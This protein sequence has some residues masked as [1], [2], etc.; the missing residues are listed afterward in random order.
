MVQ[1]CRTNLKARKAIVECETVA[2]D[3]DTGSMLPFQELMHRRRKYDI[4]KVMEMYPVGLFFF[5]AIYV[6]DED[7]TDRP[8]LERRK[9]L[10]EIVVPDENIGLTVA[11]LVEDPEGLDLFMRRAVE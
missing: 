9:V 3:P 7:L 1:R 2:L 11:R 4:E 8:L 10:E 5:D 6:D